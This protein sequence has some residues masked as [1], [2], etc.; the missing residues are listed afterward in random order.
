[1]MPD[2]KT[3]VTRLGLTNPLLGMYDSPDTSGFEPLITLKPGKHMCI[4]RFYENFLKG[5]TLQ[6]TKDNFGCGGAGSHLCG[7]Q[8]RSREDYVT[9][10]FEGEGLK[11]TR[12]IMENWFDK[13]KP[14][15]MENPYILMGPLRPEKYELLK[16]VTFFVNPDQLS[17]LVIG[18][19]YWSVPGDPPAVIA[20]FGSG[21]MELLPLFE[22]LQRPQAIIGATD[23]AMRQYLPPDIL[24]FTV[25]VPMFEQLCSLDEKSFLFKPFIKNL[26][27]SRASAS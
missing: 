25:T 11:A 4:F 18:A 23:I 13:R 3:L 9:F 21:C 8:T 14:Y 17:M 6:I 12:P 19:N 20:P 15:E 24:A 5:E 2:Q 16:T 27:K 7:V 22:D 26:K 1:M 10:L